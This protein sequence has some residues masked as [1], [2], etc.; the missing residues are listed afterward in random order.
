MKSH[1]LTVAT[2]AVSLD[3]YLSVSVLT[4]TS[5]IYQYPV[6]GVEN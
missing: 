6:S 4:L 5:A 3:P 1:L 2:G